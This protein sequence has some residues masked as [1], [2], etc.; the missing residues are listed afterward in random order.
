[1]PEYHHGTE[2]GAAA[3]VEAETDELRSDAL[4]LAFGG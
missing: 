4:V 2:T 3:F 1:M